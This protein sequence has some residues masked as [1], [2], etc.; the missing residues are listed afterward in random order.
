VSGTPICEVIFAA[1]GQFADGLPRVRVKCDDAGTD[2]ARARCSVQGFVDTNALL[3]DAGDLATP[4]TAATARRC[5]TLTSRAQTRC[6]SGRTPYCAHTARRL[7]RGGVSV[8]CARTKCGTALV[9]ARKACR[10]QGGTPPAVRIFTRLTGLRFNGAPIDRVTCAICT[11]TT[12]REA[13]VCADGS[14]RESCR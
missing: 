3:A 7:G 14:C 8:E 1:K 12:C 9:R 10:S 11:G 13:A 4:V 6:G 2:Q 5:S